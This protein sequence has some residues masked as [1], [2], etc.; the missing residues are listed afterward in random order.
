MWNIKYCSLL[1]GYKNPK[2]PQNI[3]TEI[4]TNHDNENPSGCQKKG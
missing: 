3:R 1:L 2:G 4:L